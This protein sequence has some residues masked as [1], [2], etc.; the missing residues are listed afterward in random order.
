MRAGGGA[1]GPGRRERARR[2][3]P[4]G[5]AGEGAAERGGLGRRQPFVCLTRR[6]L[7]GTAR[8]ASGGSFL[9]RLLPQPHNGAMTPSA[10]RG[11]RPPGPPRPRPRPRPRPHTTCSPR[12]YPGP[13]RRALSPPLP[14]SPGPP[15][16]ASEP[17]TPARPPTSTPPP[18]ARRR[19]SPSFASCRPAAL[20]GS[21]PR[22]GGAPRPPSPPL[23]GHPGAPLP[24]CRLPGAAPSRP[25][26]R[27]AAPSARP[28]SLPPPRPGS[29]EVFDLLRRALNQ[30]ERRGGAFHF[31]PLH[32][33]WP[34]GAFQRVS[35]RKTASYIIN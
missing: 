34:L 19:S 35:H 9:P 31:S 24:P 4:P 25:G 17:R 32:L 16:P 30:E 15:F 11:R 22:L 8:G 23:R 2:V 21:W 3:P 26:V 29:R 20:A 7:P 1:P 33:Y 6:C 18:A 12:G 10:G 14:P 28:C 13:G 5:G 27:N